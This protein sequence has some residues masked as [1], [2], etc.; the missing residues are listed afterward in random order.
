VTGPTSRPADPGPAAWRAAYAALA[1][2]P[3][4][5]R[6]LVLGWIARGGIDEAQLTRAA[7]HRRA[8]L[9]ESGQRAEKH[10]PPAGH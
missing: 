1:A 5:R 4:A 8:G 7:T 2:L 6:Q 3:P 9:A 10:A